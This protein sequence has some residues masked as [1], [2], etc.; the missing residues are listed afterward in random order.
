MENSYLGKAEDVGLYCW[1][2]KFFVLF[3]EENC[4]DVDSGRRGNRHGGEEEGDL[5]MGT[6]WMLL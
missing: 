4:R 5:S 1:D 6:V 3:E 2:V